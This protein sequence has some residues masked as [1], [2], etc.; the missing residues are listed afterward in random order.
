MF[1]SVNQRRRAFTLIE[2]LVV[3]SIIAVLIALLLPAVQQAREAAR[4]TQ[5]KNNLKQLGLAV[6]NYE[7]TF[8]T[9]PP[10]IL[11]AP[12][13]A[14]APFLFPY[15][16]Q[17]I[18]Y[19]FNV[20]WNH[21]NNATIVNPQTGRTNNQAVIKVLVCPSAPGTSDRLSLAPAS[22]QAAPTD[23]CPFINLSVTAFPNPNLTAVTGSPYFGMNLSGNSYFDDP[24]YPG[25]MG[26]NVFRKMRDVTDGLS[27]TILM[28][29][30]AG[31]P[32][33]WEKGKLINPAPTGPGVSAAFNGYWANVRCSINSYGFD[34]NNPASPVGPCAVNCSNASEAY[35]FHTG[36]A[37]ILMG[38]GSVRFI[39]A[40]IPY[41]LLTA[42]RTRSF[43]EVIETP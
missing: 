21:A 29:E 15:I 10:V 37:Q 13:T 43:G 22:P 16:E 35:S 9:V 19:D 24:Q 17:K 25:I 28:V 4:R 6:H 38:D 32:Q 41:F 40:N 31:R 5:C 8:S 36:G 27:N 30:C 11:A 1:A 42:M 33:V 20:A 14:W 34:P 2:L 3:I 39:S 7:S 23:Y 12:Q 18:P 26:L